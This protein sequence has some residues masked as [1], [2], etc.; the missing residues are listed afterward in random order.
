MA[1]RS[2]PG[3]SP[4]FGIFATIAALLLVFLVAGP[5]MGQSP[6]PTATEEPTAT[7]AA[8]PAVSPAGQ[9]PGATPT[10]PDTA[11]GDPRSTDSGSSPI[12]LLLLGIAA[13]AAVLVYLGMRSQLRRQP[14]GSDREPPA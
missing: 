2:N 3:R 7:A 11:I 1:Q 5:A 10:Q 6:S 12:A 8:S 9:T 14:A 13:V 4:A